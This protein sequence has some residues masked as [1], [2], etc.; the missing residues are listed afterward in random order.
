MDV[1]T[2]PL[3]Q[4]ITDIASLAGIAGFGLTVMVY[5]TTRSLKA[6][7]KS[8]VRIPLIHIELQK[9]TSSINDALGDWDNRKEFIRKEFSNC[10]VYAESLR[11]KLPSKE[12]S[13]TDDFL[14]M[15]KP[16][17]WFRR[18]D[19][20]VNINDQEQAWGLY[21]K[22]SILNSRVDEIVKDMQLD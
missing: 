15:V 14:N 16:N 20:T 1:L 12:R 8:K 3:S 6:A 11:E 2:W 9:R 5:F 19:I 21:E 10:A 17:K 13:K 7:L 18:N 4:A 22:L